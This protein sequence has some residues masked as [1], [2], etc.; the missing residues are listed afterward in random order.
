M[1]GAKLHSV[2]THLFINRTVQGVFFRAKTKTHAD[3]LGLKGYVK[4]LSDGRV[5]ICVE[6]EKV[7]ELIDF[8]KKEPSPV[9]IDHI[10]RETRP[11]QDAYTGFT[12]EY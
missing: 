6:G 10:E 12:I 4:N 5:E 8:L 2:E 7:D 9:S 3:H 1:I 11:L